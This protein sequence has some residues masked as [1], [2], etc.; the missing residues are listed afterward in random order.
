[1]GLR[2]RTVLGAVT[3]ALLLAAAPAG[4]AETHVL[5]GSLAVGG[6]PTQVAVHEATGDI[7]VLNGI[8]PASIARFDSSGA[9][10]DF[11]LL[12]TNVIDGVGAGE[13]DNNNRGSFRGSQF[14][15]DNSGGINDGAIYVSV[16][17]TFNSGMEADVYLPTG[18][19][20]G[21]L[22]ENSD[23]FLPTAGGET[24]GIAVSPDGYVYLT[25]EYKG[26]FPREGF[27]DKFRP[28]RWVPD[29]VPPQVWPIRGSLYNLDE[30]TCRTSADSTNAV[31]VTTA[32]AITALAPLKQYPA[33][34]FNTED[35]PSRTITETANGSYIDVS[36]DDLYVNELTKVSRYDSEGMLQETFAVGEVSPFIG[37][38]A[39]NAA[40]GTAYVSNLLTG[41][42][43]TYA[44]VTT[45]DVTDISVQPHPTS[46]DLSATLGTAGAGAIESC[47]VEFGTS[48]EYGS[49]VPCDS[50]PASGGEISAEL[51]GL[52]LDTTYHYRVV[53]GNAN[54]E[55]KTPNRT[56]TTRAVRNLRMEE[57]M[58]VTRNSATVRASF[59]GAGEET[60]YVFE[61]STDKTF[62]NKTE[63]QS[64]GSGTGPQSISAEIAGLQTNT[65]YYVRVIATS[66]AGTTTS[67]PLRFKT[68]P[69][70]LPGVADTGVSSVTP[71]GATL[72]ASIN[73]GFGPTVYMFEYGLDPS[74]GS[75][76]AIS[77]SIG[78]D[79]AP[80]PVEEQVSGLLPGR[81]YFFRAVAI[82]FSGTTNG[83]TLSFN[84]PAVPSVET[85]A[86]I[87]VSE[88]GATLTGLVTPGFRPTTYW[89][90]YGPTPAY[91]LSTPASG[92]TAA[93]NGAHSVSA[94]VT[95]LAP[96]TTYHYR[97]VASNEI[98]QS[99][100]PDLT[101]T[102]APAATPAPVA[103]G[104]KPLKCKRNQVK[105]KGKCVKRKAAKKKRKGKKKAGKKRGQRRSS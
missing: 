5:T 36:N 52:S 32:K 33:S 38:V 92:P 34:V 21:R 27:I 63:S 57:P 7:Y 29:S 100:G 74:F 2:V 73:P 11:P 71:T 91:G 46:A 26:V 61:W 30:G 97:V 85:G 43:L 72:E 62:S 58:N 50:V 49:S 13:A 3:A 93:D 45:P 86:A 96:G 53:A 14:A 69:P 48:E 25:H 80:H 89:F 28:G 19:Y 18:K 22:T 8:V 4:A 24:C 9:P 75:E 15:I 104:R 64:A 37:G 78:D 94:V 81:T 103:V 95:G 105:R 76:T 51:P 44:A 10:K 59:L 42:V 79:G 67:N 66:P 47:K 40:T 54:G 39:V 6:N 88:A 56:F 65:P 83:P 77:D 31:Y 41:Q 35:P 68:A 84:T 12:G 16:T 1:M 101:F 82:N 20:T 70:E 60:S 55:T 17:G 90:E 87:G 98:G 102:T 99:V 23:E